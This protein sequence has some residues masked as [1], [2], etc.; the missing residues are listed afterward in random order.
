MMAKQI[1]TIITL[2]IFTITTVKG[3]S[4]KEES[5]FAGIVNFNGWI[6]KLDSIFSELIEKER[7]A[8]CIRKLGYIGSDL[9]YIVNAKKD[10]LLNIESGDLKESDKMINEIQNSTEDLIVNA[11]KLDLLIN[12]NLGKLG[13][14]CWNKLE[15]DLIYEKR[16][17][18]SSMLKQLKNRDMDMLLSDSKLAI[19]LLN[20]ASIL[21][22][23][24]RDD[25]RNIKN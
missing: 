4:K 3:Q 8:E 6:E 20:E 14:D 5:L 25:L 11:R 23:K 12:D 15:D 13:N 21:V 2:C 17:M 7:E 18:H 10:F 9:E 24:L 19:S 16:K 22:W 1:F